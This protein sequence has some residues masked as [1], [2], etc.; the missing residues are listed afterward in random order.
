MRIKREI[1]QT[2]DGP[3]W[4]CPTCTNENPRD[5]EWFP[6]QFDGR[7]CKECKREAAAAERRARG[8]PEGRGRHTTIDDATVAEIR[9][10]YQQGVT[11]HRELAKQF[12]IDR[13]TA[14]RIVNGETRAG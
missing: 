7:T 5:N 10:R 11:S 8:I 3:M 14:G 6:D 12:G 2:I 1:I 9:A 4:V 13:R